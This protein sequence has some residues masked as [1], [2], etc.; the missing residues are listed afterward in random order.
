MVVSTELEIEK[1]AGRFKVNEYGNLVDI[2]EISFDQLQSLLT[3]YEGKLERSRSHDM[4]MAYEQCVKQIRNFMV[5]NVIENRMDVFS[6]AYQMGLKD[7]RSMI[8][9][10]FG[11]LDT[12]EELAK[13]IIKR[14]FGRRKEI[15]GGCDLLSDRVVKEIFNLLRVEKLEKLVLSNIQKAANIFSDVYGISSPRIKLEPCSQERRSLF[16]NIDERTIYLYLD[17][18][19]GSLALL[20][21]TIKGLFEHLCEIRSWKFHRDPLKSFEVQRQ[22][23]ERYMERFAD[24]CV[25][26]GLLHRRKPET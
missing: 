7:I 25:A 6:I 12:E 10:Y 11:K 22:E 26:M 16:Y 18:I 2:K 20:E 3:Y 19:S 8:K 9:T 24:R 17:R 1:E 21:F 13:D 14:Y 15:Y 23:T 5:D 4:R